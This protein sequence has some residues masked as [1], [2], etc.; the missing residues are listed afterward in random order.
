MSRIAWSWGLRFAALIAII[1]IALATYRQ[2]PHLISTLGRLIGD[3]GPAAAAIYVVITASG[4]V[5]LPFSSLPLIPIAA[6]AWGVVLGGTLSIVGWWVG[7]M[8]AF[9]VARRFGRPAI[10]RFAGEENIVYWERRIPKHAGFFT[11]F[12]MRLLLPVEIP[13]YVLG[14]LPVI[15]VRTYAWASLLGMAPFGYVLFAMGGALADG[16]WMR[17]TIIA[18]SAA[19]AGYAVYLL[20]R[21]FSPAESAR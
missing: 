16:A 18:V 1:V 2:L 4:I 21:R 10:A 13:S 3:G 15:S 20:Y 14:L 19:C 7:A 9:I 8:I 11:V 6:A 5:V 12:L 17:L